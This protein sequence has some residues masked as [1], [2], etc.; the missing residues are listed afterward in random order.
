M[1]MAVETIV[2]ID[3]NILRTE[4]SWEKDF[5]KLNPKGIFTKLIDLIEIVVLKDKVDIGIPET[6]LFEFVK[7][8]K[9]NFDS[10]FS[11]FRKKIPLFENMEC[12]DFSQ[13]KLPEDNFDYV[14]YFNKLISE[15]NSNK[16]SIKIIKL[17]W[18]ESEQILK[19]LY[20]KVIYNKPPFEKNT[21]KGFKDNIIW[22]TILLYSKNTDYR[23]YIFLT[24]NTN[25]FIHELEKEFEERINKTIKILNTYDEIEDELTLLHSLLDFDIAVKKYIT[26]DYF[27][28]TIKDKIAEQVE[29]NSSLITEVNFETAFDFSSRDNGELREYSGLFNLEDIS[30]IV[31]LETCYVLF[32]TIIAEGKK[33]KIILLFDF[34]T[35]EIINLLVEEMGGSND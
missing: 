22:E 13:L 15:L 27:I 9:N 30:S 32:Y 1:K 5:S 11:N 3:T 20:D 21:D 12:C 29:I 34:E 14:D 23:N 33:Y 28:S 16:S 24:E 25:D 6:V 7:C 17:D 18:S 31:D 35:K 19:N 26:N 10:A 8:K 2:Y 4:Q